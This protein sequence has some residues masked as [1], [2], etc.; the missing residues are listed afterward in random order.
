MLIEVDIRYGNRKRRIFWSVVRDCSRNSLNIFSIGEELYV[1][2]K[3]AKVV[4]WVMSC[5]KKM[6]KIGKRRKLKKIGCPQVE[7]ENCMKPNK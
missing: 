5:M 4:S 7:N 3:N 2:T 6:K 1:L